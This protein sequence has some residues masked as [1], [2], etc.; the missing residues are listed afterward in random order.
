MDIEK[1]VHDFIET[2]VSNI[3][4]EYGEVGVAIYKVG[5]LEALMLMQEIVK[6]SQ[7]MVVSDQAWMI[8]QL[9]KDYSQDGGIN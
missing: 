4:E 7:G 2:R 8:Q 6:A 9:F 5:F 1:I 3:E